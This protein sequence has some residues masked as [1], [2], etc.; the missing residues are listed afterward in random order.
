MYKEL[1]NDIR[2]LKS[3]I[4]DRQILDS[5]EE[6]HQWIKDN[7]NLILPEKFTKSIPYDIKVNPTKYIKY[8]MYINNET[9]KLEQNHMLL[10]LKEIIL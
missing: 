9:E 7:I 4:I 8:S 3:D 1:N 10:Y 5:K 2:N 6:Y